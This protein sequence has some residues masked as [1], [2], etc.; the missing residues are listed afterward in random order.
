M[1][2]S[3][4]NCCEIGN[5]NGAVNRKLNNALIGL[6]ASGTEYCI[7]RAPECHSKDPGFSSQECKPNSTFLCLATVLVEDC[8]GGGAL[9]GVLSS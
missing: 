9:V 8:F 1:S 7:S 5:G 3:W 6:P 4:A 2:L